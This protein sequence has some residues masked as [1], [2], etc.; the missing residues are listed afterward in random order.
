MRK[1]IAMLATLIACTDEYVTDIQDSQPPTQDATVPEKCEMET[2]QYGYCPREFQPQGAFEATGVSGWSCDCTEEQMEEFED[3]GEAPDCCTWTDSHPYGYVYLT[4]RSE[5]DGTI[6]MQTESSQAPFF[7]SVFFGQ[8]QLTYEG[9]M[10]MDKALVM[11]RSYA[12]GQESLAGPYKIRHYLITPKLDGD[13]LTLQFS[14]AYPQPL[15]EEDSENFRPD[16]AV[17]LKMMGDVTDCFDDAP[18]RGLKFGHCHAGPVCRR[19]IAGCVPEFACS[20]LTKDMTYFY[21][22]WNPPNTSICNVRYYDQF[23]IYTDY[24][25]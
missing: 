8:Y 25:M 19:L 20:A 24:Y 21:S 23:Y 9:E 5:H 13:T 2:T 12:D 18:E 4:P 7:G 16:F 11:L 1:F 3:T 6:V 10:F 14:I 15:F 22:S 17:T